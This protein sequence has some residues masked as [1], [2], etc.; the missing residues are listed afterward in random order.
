MGK[1]LDKLRGQALSSANA[2]CIARQA[3]P[4]EDK[5]SKA[6]TGPNH[7]TFQL[8]DLNAFLLTRRARVCNRPYASTRPQAIR[9]PITQKTLGHGQTQ[10]GI[11][12]VLQGQKLDKLFARA[13]AESSDY[14][15]RGRL[16]QQTMKLVSIQQHLVVDTRVVA[17][18]SVQAKVGH[19]IGVV[20]A[21]RQGVSEHR[22]VVAFV[23]PTN[24][25]E[26]ARPHRSDEVWKAVDQLFPL[27]A[28][29]LHASRV[30]HQDAQGTHRIGHIPERACDHRSERPHGI[31]GRHKPGY[32]PQSLNGAARAE[33][34]HR[35]LEAGGLVLVQ[36][37]HLPIKTKMV[38]DKHGRKNPIDGGGNSLAQNEVESE[39]GTCRRKSPVT[40]MLQVS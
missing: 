35:A 9:I 11:A 34:S 23:V 38:I 18:S 2:T 14:A 6:R 4:K 24:F 25:V 3:Q 33:D 10:R 16:R 29:A 5:M 15:K 32:V 19:G 21:H 12:L 37:A 26:L 36:E 28:R 7:G 31:L 13:S 39:R 20:V 22:I 40:H 30:S 17:T 1:L 27:V 8:E